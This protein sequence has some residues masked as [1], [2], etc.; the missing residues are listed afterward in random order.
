MAKIK[1][2]DTRDDIKE[3]VDERP[4]FTNRIAPVLAPEIYVTKDAGKIGVLHAEHGKTKLDLK[5]ALD[6]SFVRGEWSL[7]TNRFETEEFG[8]EE[9]TEEVESLLLM[10]DLDC[11][12]VAGELATDL[13]LTNRDNR[14]ATGLFNTSVFTGARNYLSVAAGDA[15]N[16]A[17]TKIATQVEFAADILRS[18]FVIKQN[19]LDLVMARKAFN[20]AV[21]QLASLDTVKYTNS[22]LLASADTQMTALRDY[23]NLGRII[24]IDDMIGKHGIDNN[25]ET[26]DEDFVDL[27]NPDFALLCKLAPSVNSWKAGG[28]ARQPVFAPYS[29][30]YRIESYDEP[31]TKHRYIRASEY[32]GLFIDARYGFLFNN[33]LA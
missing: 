18:R 17:G 6:G 5:R 4:I 13:L 24:L 14:I 3:M 33:V 15:W 30:D 22:L 19:E 25:D 20:A 9:P 27:V 21:R 7:G 1:G 2:L 10:D 16:V 23:L 26:D 29:K 8:V 28:V 11:E 12:A 31:K 32:R